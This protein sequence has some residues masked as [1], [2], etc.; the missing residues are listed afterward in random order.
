MDLSGT[1]EV[2]KGTCK[3]CKKPRHY[4]KDYKSKKKPKG[5]RLNQGF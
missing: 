3:N 1:K 4:I 5:Q 2:K